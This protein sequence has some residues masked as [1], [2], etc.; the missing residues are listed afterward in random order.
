[1]NFHFLWYC[2]NPKLI[3]RKKDGVGKNTE[4]VAKSSTYSFL[5]S[6][7]V[8][9]SS[10]SRLWRHPG[11]D[12]M[13]G[14]GVRD[15]NKRVHQPWNYMWNS[16]PPS[17]NRRATYSCNEE[18]ERDQ[19]QWMIGIPKIF[20]LKTSLTFA[21]IVIGKF[22]AHSTSLFLK[23]LDLTL[24]NDDWQGNDD[25]NYDHYDGSRWKE[26]GVVHWW[27]KNSLKWLQ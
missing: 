11:E 23:N 4:K 2:G 8:F 22:V 26:C 25:Y 10:F 15:E 5:P 24:P 16:T 27:R 20:F 3:I 1:M 18:E 14:W 7:Y 12:L 9:T 6:F 13:T 17:H 21:T 19:E